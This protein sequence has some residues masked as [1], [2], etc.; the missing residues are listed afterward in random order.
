MLSRSAAIEQNFTS[1]HEVAAHMARQLFFFPSSDSSQ[2][3][4]TCS[5]LPLWRVNLL[6]GEKSILSPQVT[7]R[8]LFPSLAQA[9]RSMEQQAA[10]K[11]GDTVSLRAFQLEKLP[12]SRFPRSGTYCGHSMNILTVE[13][14]G[15]TECMC[16][17]MHSL[18]TPRHT[19]PCT[20]TARRSKVAQ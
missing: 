20:I 13:P 17:P 6:R 5:S 15:H 7:P 2:F 14:H 16:Q 8:V 18:G 9:Q 12:L 11:T 3:P 4:S 19:L 10:M 1:V